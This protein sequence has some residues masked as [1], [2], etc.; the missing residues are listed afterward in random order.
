M[1][2]PDPARSEPPGPKRTARFNSV[3]VLMVVLLF[4]IAGAYVWSQWSADGALDDPAGAP[5]QSAE[6]AEAPR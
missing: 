3:V 5:V 2:H 1:T 6:G 4:V